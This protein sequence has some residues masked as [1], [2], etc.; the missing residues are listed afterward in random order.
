[1][2]VIHSFQTTDGCDPFSSVIFDQAGD[3]Y[4]TTGRGAVY[5]LSPS[6]SGC[7]ETNLHSFGYGDGA[8]P[9]YGPLIFDKAGN[10]YGTTSA[11]GDL[12][13]TTSFAARM[14]AHRTTAWSSTR[15]EISMAPP[16]EEVLITTA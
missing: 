3:L 13:C 16:P 4:G 9:G 10:L 7:S 8:F 11:G 2:T 14:G 6:N 15:R 12:N 1:M 5:E